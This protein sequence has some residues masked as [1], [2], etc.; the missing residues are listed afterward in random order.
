MIRSFF[1]LLISLLQT[2]CADA[3]Q[4]VSW[5]E[6]LESCSEEAPK[7]PKRECPSENHKSSKNENTVT[8]HQDPN[9]GIQ[10]ALDYVYKNL[11]F[12]PLDKVIILKPQITYPSKTKKFEIQINNAKEHYNSL[13]RIDATSRVIFAFY[14]IPD[15]ANDSNLL[16]A[17]PII[18]KSF[19]YSNENSVTLLSNQT[20]IPSIKMK[21]PGLLKPAF[22]IINA[23]VTFQ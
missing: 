21:N 17:G 13:K 1:F 23:D 2:C 15:F 9:I 11:A 5:H 14:F 8:Y 6:I 18:V 19:K 7:T 3:A 12:L 22:V 20:T 16:C 4:E 10:K